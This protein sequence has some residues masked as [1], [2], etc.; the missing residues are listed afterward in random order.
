MKKFIV[1]TFIFM[2]M[3]LLVGCTSTLSTDDQGNKKI[4]FSI[5]ETANV[6]DT[7]IKINS[8]KRITKDCLYKY[9]GKC[10]SYTKPDNDYFIL[11]DLTIENNG[12]DTLAISS[13][14]SFSL[15]DSE[16][17]QGEYALLT[18]SITSQLDDE[19]MAGDKLKGQIAFDV[20]DSEAYYFYY[21]DSLIDEPI[22]F[23]INKS[24]II[25]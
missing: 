20:K 10:Q 17:E 18:D 11:I 13:I 22:K 4:E 19:I 8:I 1:S 2:S 12:D 15:K 6:N 7:K 21:E 5:S 25:S 9:N 14:M 3:F 24:D 16:G 23:I